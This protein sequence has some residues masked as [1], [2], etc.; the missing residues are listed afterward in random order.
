MFVDDFMVIDK[1]GD[2]DHH[3]SDFCVV[4]AMILLLLNV[5]AEIV[6]MA[7]ESYPQQ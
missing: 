3:S 4:V 1:K 2:N 6:F 5:V 7:L